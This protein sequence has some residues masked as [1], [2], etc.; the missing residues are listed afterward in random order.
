LFWPSNEHQRG[1]ISVFSCRLSA[2]DGKSDR[3]LEGIPLPALE[4]LARQ[5][6]WRRYTAGQRIDLEQGRPGAVL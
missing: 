2:H 3:L 4:E 5:C 6:R 1:R